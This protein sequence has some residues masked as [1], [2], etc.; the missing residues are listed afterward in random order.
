[1]QRETLESALN[2]ALKQQQAR[3]QETREAAPDAP[4]EQSSCLLKALLHSA[5]RMDK[6]VQRRIGLEQEPVLYLE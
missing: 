5:T 2:E 1:M 6:I 4:P 3:L